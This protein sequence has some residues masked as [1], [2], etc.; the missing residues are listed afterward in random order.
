MFAQNAVFTFHRRFRFAC[1]VN[2][3]VLLVKLD[4][5]Q[6]K[7][8]T[9]PML[10]QNLDNVVSS[11]N[12]YVQMYLLVAD[13]IQYTGTQGFFADCN[14]LAFCPDIFQQPIPGHKSR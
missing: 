7:V 2:C 6:P 12:N 4:G 8:C 9:V 14:L 1:F 13:Q 3:F 5:V 10:K 11:H